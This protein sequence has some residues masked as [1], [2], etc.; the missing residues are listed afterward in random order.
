SGVGVRGAGARRTVTA[1]HTFARPGRYRVRLLLSDAYGR[2]LLASA[3][4]VIVVRP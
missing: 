3:S 1:S 4:T 2:A